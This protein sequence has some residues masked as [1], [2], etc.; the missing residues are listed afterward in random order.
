MFSRRKVGQALLYADRVKVQVTDLNPLLAKHLIGKHV[1]GQIIPFAGVSP[2][3]RIVDEEK[4]EKVLRDPSFEPFNENAKSKF[5]PTWTNLSE[6]AKTHPVVILTGSGL[7]FAR[8]SEKEWKIKHGLA[9][10][11]LGL[12]RKPRFYLS[13]LSPAPISK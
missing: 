10:K 6:V 5:P 11:F 4:I 12:F 9:N 13:E 8:N 7:V 1:P 2:G 3:A